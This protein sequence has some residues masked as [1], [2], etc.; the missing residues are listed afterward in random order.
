[1][2]PT[3]TLLPVGMQTSGQRLHG[4]APTTKQPALPFLSAADESLDYVHF[5]CPYENEDKLPSL[6]HH[7]KV[8]RG[9]G[10]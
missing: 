9:C 8:S 3:E 2:E 10:A 5:M 7:L 1:M 4:P 6:F